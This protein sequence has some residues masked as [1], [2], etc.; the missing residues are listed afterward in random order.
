MIING[1][2]FKVK[3]G[4]IPK[5]PIEFSEESRSFWA[6]EKKKCIEGYSVGG[7]WMPGPLY[8]YINYGT[9]LLNVGENSK[10]KIPA[11]PFLRDI[12]WEFFW[13][14]A[15]ARGLNGFLKKGTISNTPSEVLGSIKYIGTDPGTP[16][17]G[18][19]AKD[20]MMMGPREY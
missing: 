14:W 19:Q 7:K 13:A 10:T 16:I 20:L 11:K 15:V 3:P 8:F 9:I 5:I 2:L 18:N 12:E 6:A 1:E 4:D 17:Y